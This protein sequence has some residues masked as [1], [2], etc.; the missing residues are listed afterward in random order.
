MIALTIYMLLEW[1]KLIEDTD[2]PNGILKNFIITNSK[3]KS[4]PLKTPKQA[5]SGK[6]LNYRN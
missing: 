3:S 1:G 2:F 4:H 6:I 5:Y